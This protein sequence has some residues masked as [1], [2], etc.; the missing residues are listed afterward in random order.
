MHNA[1]IDEFLEGITL[2]KAVFDVRS[3]GEFA[4]GHIPGARSLPLFLDDERAIV[5]T[6]YKKEGRQAAI[7]EGLDFV[8]PK[9]RRFV[10]AV[11]AAVGPPPETVQLYCWRGG[12]RS[13]S[14]AWLLG[15]VGYEV[16]VLAGGYKSYRRWVL[17]ELARALDFRVLAGPTGVGK[18]E[19]LKELEKLGEP[20]LDLEGIANHRGSAFGGLLLSEQPTQQQFENQL[21]WEIARLRAMKRPVWVEDESRMIGRCCLPDGVMKA[22]NRAPVFVVNATRESRLERLVGIY[23]RASKEELF[24]AFEGIKRRL[25]GLRMARAQAAV[26]AGDLAAAAELALQY[27]DKAYATGLR[28]REPEM[29][30]EVEIQG[31]PGKVARHLARLH[32]LESVE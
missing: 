27:Y 3:P 22:K 12:M 21:S 9:M 8:G 1:E 23:G 29:V 16:V 20:I 15:L 11:Q 17:A 18:T 28:Q 2:G 10:E 13:Q 25:G 14:M 30:H 7:L 24:Q 32:N 6:L 26:E 4:S 19:I 31:E 5:G